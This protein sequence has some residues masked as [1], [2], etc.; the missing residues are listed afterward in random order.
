MSMTIEAFEARKKLLV[1]RGYSEEDAQ[2][3]S[4]CLGDVIEEVDGKW[5]VRDEDGKEIA[6]IDPL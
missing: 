1:E 4:V 2:R 3:L 6:R 5:V